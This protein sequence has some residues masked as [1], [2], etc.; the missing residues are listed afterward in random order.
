MPPMDPRSRTARDFGKIADG[1]RRHPT[2]AR[3]FQNAP[4]V[5]EVWSPRRAAPSG[6]LRRGTTV[7]TSGRAAHSAA[8][9]LDDALRN[10]TLQLFGDRL[11]GSIQ[12]HKVLRA[13]RLGLVRAH[14]GPGRRSAMNDPFGSWG[15]EPCP[16]G[17]R[18][19]VSRARR[20]GDLLRSDALGGV[21]RGD[22]HRAA[23]Y[24][25]TRRR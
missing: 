6:S 3:H 15:I 4:I 24:L 7:L 2:R 20:D 1:Q 11:A 17:R 5:D 14:I 22:V 13:R 19:A 16:A 23:A 10:T 9:T 25:T 18:G 12:P 21:V 8:G